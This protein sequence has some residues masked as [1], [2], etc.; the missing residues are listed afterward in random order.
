MV[1]VYK[2]IQKHIFTNTTHLPK[3]RNANIKD[4]SRK[5]IH[6]YDNTKIIKHA[7]SLLL[8]HYLRITLAGLT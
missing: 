5:D 1:Q 6:V 2:Y 8:L 7:K 3:S 4:K